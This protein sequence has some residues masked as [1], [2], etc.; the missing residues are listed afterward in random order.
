M[1]PSRSKVIRALVLVACV[2]LLLAPSALVA[3]VWTPVNLEVAAAAVVVATTLARS[4]TVWRW[5]GAIVASIII[6]VP[7]YPYWLF[8]SNQRGWY[9]HFFHGFTIRTVPIGTFVTV[10][11]LCLAIFRFV[12]WAVS[13]RP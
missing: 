9:L 11:V 4:A 1:K 6:A 2:T 7:P 13:Q 10:M 12:H 5:A 3:S 8:A